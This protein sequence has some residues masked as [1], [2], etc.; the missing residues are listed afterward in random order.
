MI[1]CLSNI[2]WFAVNRQDLRLFSQLYLIMQKVVQNLN[3]IL[4]WDPWASPGPEAPAARDVLTS[5]PAGRA[6]DACRDRRPSRHAASGR[7]ADGG[8]STSPTSARC[9]PL[10][11]LR[12]RNQCSFESSSRFLL[13]E[14]HRCCQLKLRMKITTGIW[15][16]INPSQKEF[17]PVD[18]Y[19]HGARR[20]FSL[21]HEISPPL[22][23][24]GLIRTFLIQALV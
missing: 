22:V 9:Q 19:M 2:F 21:K 8:T 20:N 17:A 10:S 24:S 6:S 16:P 23:P 12:Q 15:I 1:M 13:Q 4:T 14:I 7:P 3:V 11:Y 18:L 5:R